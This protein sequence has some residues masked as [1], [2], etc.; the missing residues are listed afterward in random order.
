VPGEDHDLGAVLIANYLENKGWTVHFTGP[1]A[2]AADILKAAAG[3]SADAVFLSVTLVAN[4]IAASELLKALKTKAPGARSA[5]GGRAA[6]VAREIL[7]T[8]ADFV[9]Q[10]LEAEYPVILE[11][12]GRHA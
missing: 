11:R 4:L 7:R 12:T 3:F 5:V 1:S 8:M 6:A 10:D 2:P 9:I